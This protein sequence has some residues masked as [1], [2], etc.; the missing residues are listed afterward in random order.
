MSGFK[1]AKRIL[2]KFDFFGVNFSFKYKQEEKYKTS[3]GGFIFLVFCVVVAVVGIYYFIPFVNRKN[4][5]MVYYSMNLQGAEEINFHKSKA[6]FGVGFACS[7][8]DDGTKV[9]DI[10]NFT[11]NYVIY[12][13]NKDGSRT[14]KR[15]VLTTHPCNYGDFYNNF[16][17]SLDVIGM[18]DFMCID[19][20]D[21]VI[22]GIYTDEVFSYYEFSVTAKEDSVTNFNRIDKYLTSNDCRLELYYTD[23]TIDLYDY[24]EPIKPYI[25]SIF[26]QLNPTLFLKMNAYF[27]NQYFQNDNYLVFNFDEADPLVQ[28]LYSRYEEY[29]LYKGTNRGVTKPADYINY[30]KMYIRADTKKTEIKRKYQKFMEFYADSSSLL[31]ALFEILFIILNFIN[32]FYAEHSVTKNVFLFKELENK[33]FD[34]YQK[35]FE[36][37]ELLSLTELFTDKTEKNKNEERKDTEYLKGIESENIKIYNRRREAKIK[38]QEKEEPTSTEKKL[39]ANV[40]I[41]TIR[42]KNIRVQKM[43]SYFRRRDKSEDM[44][45]YNMIS[46]RINPTRNDMPS[47]VRLNLRNS[48]IGS[49]NIVPKK[50]EE[51]SIER[52]KLKLSSSFNIFEIFVSNFCRPCMCK[53][54]TLKSALNLKSVDILYKELDI[55]LH[56]RNMI[57]LDIMNRIILEDHKRD[58]SKFISRPIL[59]LYNDDEKYFNDL[60]INF[61]EQD[62]NN[63]YDNASEIIQRP[64]KTKI[65]TKLVSI[66]YEKLNN[67]L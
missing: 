2:K 20:K 59:S 24:E 26:I 40:E 48:R 14:K 30:A 46:N 21:D 36:I 22:A 23:I 16:N 63:F 41:K 51:F 49:R 61:C 5:S 8:D 4:F 10:L 6:A 56:V 67:L 25:N 66:F 18:S 19:K 39:D 60:N 53:N 54:L 11:L 27:M 64:Q 13:K 62:F 57:L 7:V 44:N 52:A 17:E 43:N 35:H 55:A 9:D 12:L 32:T 45:N 42:N 15:T 65:E 31:I 50:M 47:R 1:V 38:L 58:I 3:L 37:K 34:V 28:I 29:S 33:H